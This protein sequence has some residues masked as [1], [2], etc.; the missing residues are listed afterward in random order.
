MELR[1][2]TDRVFNN[3][4]E[5]MADMPKD[6]HIPPVALIF[7]GDKMGLIPTEPFASTGPAWRS[8][9]AQ[10]IQGINQQMGGVEAFCIMDPKNRWPISCGINGAEE[11]PSRRYG[12]G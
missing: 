6:S 4:R 10:V 11:Q 9:L 7:Q 5:A 12:A 3:F 1:E 8:V 2:I